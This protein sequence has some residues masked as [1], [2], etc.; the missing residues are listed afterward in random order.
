MPGRWSVLGK[1][2]HELE[3]DVLGPTDARCIQLP[4]GAAE[5]DCVPTDSLPSGSVTSEGGVAKPPTTIGDSF[6]FLCSS[7]GFCPVQCAVVWCTLL[8]LLYLLGALTLH[9]RIM[10]S[11]SLVIFFALKSAVSQINIVT[12]F[13][14]ISVSV[15]YFLHLVG[16]CR[17]LH[18]K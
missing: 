14:K 8:G 11:L 1:A 17:P 5:F 7:V 9:H 3:K 16:T 10:P 15:L 13:F 4:A 6:L 2:P 18:L 12:P